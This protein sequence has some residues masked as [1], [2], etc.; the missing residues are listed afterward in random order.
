ML[1]GSI[2]FDPSKFTLLSGQNGTCTYDD[3]GYLGCVCDRTF[4]PRKR[5]CRALLHLCDDEPGVDPVDVALL[6]GSLFRL[7]AVPIH[8]GHCCV[9]DQRKRV[10]GGSLHNAFCGLDCTWHDYPVC[11]LRQR[12]TRWVADY[13]VHWLRRTFGPALRRGNVVYASGCA[14]RGTLGGLA[15]SAT[16]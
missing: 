13:Q 5:G 2:C 11:F 12:R 10:Q 14:A 15:A 8:S 1:T 6:G 16:P 4:C 3:F 9:L 7:R